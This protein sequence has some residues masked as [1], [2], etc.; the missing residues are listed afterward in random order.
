M[1]SDQISKRLRSCVYN[2]CSFVN[3][4]IIFRSSRRIK[5]FFQYKDRLNRS[6][7][8]KVI[9]KT[10]CWDCSDFYIMI[11][12]T[13]RLQNFDFKS[14]N[15][16]L[17]VD[18]L[19]ENFKFKLTKYKIDFQN[20]KFK[21]HNRHW[22]MVNSQLRKTQLS[23]LSFHFDHPLPNAFFSE[24]VLGRIFLEVRHFLF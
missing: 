5:S 14:L 15:S 16:K 19:N 23:T 13:K 7:K 11:G 21:C 24:C 8:S 6:Q 2:F 20:W 1:Q 12:K 9:Y 10:A 3:L 17:K 22:T 4:K 18:L